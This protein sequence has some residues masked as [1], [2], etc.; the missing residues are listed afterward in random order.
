MRATQRSWIRGRL[1]L[2]VAV[3][4]T[5]VLGPAAGLHGG[6]LECR[7]PFE[8]DCLGSACVDAVGQEIVLVDADGNGLCEWPSGTTSFT[9]TL[10]F[11]EETPCE[12]LE[13][14]RIEAGSLIVEPGGRLVAV[15][16]GAR[17]VT[18][19][20]IDDLI[21]LGTLDVGVVDDIVLQAT[22]GS[23]HLVGPMALEAADRVLI[24]AHEGDVTLAPP[25]LDPN[26]PF[27]DLF[28]IL[29]RTMSILAEGPDGSVSISRA[30]L[31]ARKVEVS[32]WST[33]A[34][35]GPKT[36]HVR[37][38]A[39]LTTDLERTGLGGTTVSDVLLRSRGPI[40]VSGGVDLDSSRHVLIETAQAGDDLCLAD[41]VRLEARS[42]LGSER[43][44]DLLEVRGRV[45]DD[46]TTTFDGDLRGEVE[47]G[48]CEVDLPTPTPVPTGGPVPVVTVTTP[49]GP[50]PLPLPDLRMAHWRFYVRIARTGGAAVNVNVPLS[51]EAPPLPAM[52]RDDHIPFFPINEHQK[53]FDIEA[54]GGDTLARLTSAAAQHLESHPEDYPNFGGVIEL[55]WA[56][57]DVA[58]TPTPH[59]TATPEPTVTSTRTAIAT[60]VPTAAP[61]SLATATA[62]PEATPE[63]TVV[64]TEIPVPVATATPLPEPTAVPDLETAHWRFYVRIARTTGS[65]VNVNVPLRGPEPPL[66][67]M[68]RDDHIPFFPI[69]E[70]QKR[71]DIE[72]LGGDTLAR[73]TSAAAQHIESHPEDY[74]NFG[75]VIELKWAKRDVPPTPTPT[76]TAT[77]TATPTVTPL[78]TATATVVPTEAPTA[79]A[80]A[81]ALPE[82]TPEPTV[83]PTEIPVPVATATPLPEPTAVPDLETAHWRFYVRIARTTGSAVNVNVPLRG[84]E[85]PLP[86]A[87]R[88][89]HIPF[90]P[91]NDVQKRLD[92]EALGGDTLAR[93]VSAAEQHLESHPEDYPNFGSVIEL[94]WAK[95]DV[96]P[97][98]TPTATSTPEPTDTPEPTATATVVPTDEPTPLPTVTP[99]PEATPEPSAVATPEPTDVPGP[100]PT[101]PVPTLTAGASPSPTPTPVLDT[102]QWR[103]YVRIARTTGSAINVNVP[104]K[105]EDPPIRAAIREEHVPAF[106]LNRQQTRSEIEALDSADPLGGDTLERLTAAA[107]AHLES[108]PADYPNFAGIIEL[109]WAKRVGA[110][111]TTT[112]VASKYAFTQAHITI[113]HFN[114]VEFVGLHCNP[115]SADE[116]CEF[117]C[118]FFNIA[119]VNC[120]A[121]ADSTYNGGFRSGDPGSTISFTHAFNTLGTF[122]FVSE[123]HTATPGG[124]MLG[125]VTVESSG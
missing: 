125:S 3:A 18:L 104:L 25:V 113:E 68:I 122:C 76:A 80:S 64:P 59:P 30:R 13:A 54:F 94:K 32:T 120:P 82:A 83:V 37:D 71:F 43:R 73:L 111:T 69:D 75:S 16:A 102:E 9:G 47:F 115:A 67:A 72:A 119:E 55:K 23:I 93:L 101:L 28:T 61:T 20:T 51:G 124:G 58:P 99:L 19:V 33:V 97:T 116:P 52:I 31:G 74:P 103:F 87:I 79:I 46:G 14:P 36:L 105:G 22:R 92:I 6:P 15:P 10:T 12:F 107:A 56:K 26:D 50:T 84:P 1:H 7:V 63:P 39:V 88:E 24:E 44:I 40:V 65:A 89:D 106:P 108:H 27:A 49:P 53:R 2:L 17:D 123:N 77:R 98:P 81:T 100:L 117:P 114:D 60:V 110:L 118:G 109:K 57:R 11:L 95:R 35:V 62:L 45:L 96:P 85:P 4:A 34:E 5:A 48:P 78:P 21:A 42:P 121:T 38:G 8:G 29:A 90:F 66:P 70:H 112:V 86:A 91:F 41:G